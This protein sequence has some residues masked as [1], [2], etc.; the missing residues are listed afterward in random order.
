MIARLR[1]G[2]IGQQEEGSLGSSEK[3]SC[4]ECAPKIR[5]FNLQYACS[6]SKLRI[7]D[8]PLLFVQRTGVE[9]CVA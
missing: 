9:S 4:V 2:V 3:A 8:L 5:F 6:V 1:S 7:F